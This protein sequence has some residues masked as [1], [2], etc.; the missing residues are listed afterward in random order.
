[1]N[2][3]HWISRITIGFLIIILLIS[4]FYTVESKVTGDPPNLFGYQLLVVLSG[5]MEPGI[6][7]GSII[8]VKQTDEVDYFQIGDIITYQ[9]LNDPNI[10][11]THR[12]VDMK[13][14]EA[15]VMYITKGDSN[16]VPDVM[17]V[18]AR[19]VKGV[20]AHFT[21]PYLGYF[22]SFLNTK[23]GIFL[24]MVIPGIYLIVSQISTLWRLMME[25]EKK[26]QKVNN[27]SH[28]PSDI[29]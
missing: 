28:E 8:A 18:P 22:F 13:Q 26:K 25:E 21:V 3:K 5:S 11:I 7:T 27:T 9:S 24:M 29:V 19:N 10:L 2:L 15:E 14:N 6:K 12:I 23:Y 16:D 17:P 20:Y 4:L 1:M